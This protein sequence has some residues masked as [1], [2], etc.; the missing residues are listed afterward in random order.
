VTDV[1]QISGDVAVRKA[2]EP[3]PTIEVQM[4]APVAPSEQLPQDGD[5][6]R[7]KRIGGEPIELD[8]EGKALR[9]EIPERA[10]DVLYEWKAGA[11]PEAG[12]HENFSKQIKRAS[13][14]MYNARLAALGDDYAR[15][16]T[17]SPELGREIAEAV[18]NAAPI[19]VTPVGDTG[20]PIPPLF[21][22][23]AITE[24]VSFKNLAE[25]KRGMKNFRDA[26]ERER[27]ALLQSLQAAEQQEAQRELE[28]ISQAPKPAQP[29]QP[30]PDPLAA[31]RQHL[32]A[33][34]AQ[35]YWQKLSDG[36]RA[37]AHEMAQIQQWAQ[38]AQG[39]E[40][41][42]YLG[43]AERRYG[44]LQ[45]HLQQSAQIRNAAEVNANHAWRQQV[46]N[47]ASQQDS[48]AEAA[49][50]KEMPEFSSDAGWKQLQQA[51]KRALRESTG[52]TDQQL[53]AEWQQ[54]RWRSI[55][56]QRMLARLGRD[57]LAREG[58]KN[59]NA[60]KAYTP[61][62]S[63]YASRPRGAADMDRVRDLE[64]QLASATGNSTV[65]IMTQ[66]HQAR[67]DAGLV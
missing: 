60:K 25:A 14:S 10:P 66:L 7:L 65:R 48:H 27:A 23:Q 59:L 61:P 39:D 15:L 33:Q 46:A 28:H 51:T 47:W 18:V 21:D 44:H 9:A 55:P 6:I 24:D 12:E 8:V 20:Q 11:L 43:E 63:S 31:E 2:P 30:Q 67:R 13:E 54:G 36:E 26:Q 4:P 16:P 50:K 41:A 35:L 64:R 1:V 22:D 49:I 32:A 53:T 38:Q 45:A 3:P 34:Q 40:R 19:K 57:Q 29:Q 37:A 17:V 5:D 62:V 42:A 58:M 52:L 56:E